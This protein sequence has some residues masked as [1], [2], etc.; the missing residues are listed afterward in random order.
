MCWKGIV[1]STWFW[2]HF[3]RVRSLKT[4]NRKLETQWR[5]WT[6]GCL[7]P[8][9]GPETCMGMLVT[10]AFGKIQWGFQSEDTYLWHIGMNGP[11]CAGCALPQLVST[12]CGPFPNKRKRGFWYLVVACTFVTGCLFSL[13]RCSLRDPNDV[14]QLVPFYYL[15]MELTAGADFDRHTVSNRYLASE[16]YIGRSRS[17]VR[18]W[19][20]TLHKRFNHLALTKY[21]SLHDFFLNLCHSKVLSSALMPPQAWIPGTCNPMQC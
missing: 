12:G 17:E 8:C 7:W 14:A 20:P 19:T 18:S 1:S 3:R 21:Q 2:H 13:P 11:G 4:W 5:R 10:K 15:H 6:Q 9:E 16:S